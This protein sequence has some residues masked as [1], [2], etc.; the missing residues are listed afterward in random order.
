MQGLIES[1]G[2]RPEFAVTGDSGEPVVGVETH[3]FRNGGATVVALLTNP[4]FARG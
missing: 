4:Q 2:V 3:L 1:A